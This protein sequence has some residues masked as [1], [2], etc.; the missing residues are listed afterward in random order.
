MVTRVGTGLGVLYVWQ[1]VC[2][3]VLCV[4]PPPQSCRASIIE[5]PSAGLGGVGKP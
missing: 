1:A 2:Q 5:E 4:C 3:A